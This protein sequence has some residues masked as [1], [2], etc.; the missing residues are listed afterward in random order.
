M[1]RVNRSSNLARKSIITGGKFYA[2]R[3]NELA[4]SPTYTAL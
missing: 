3:Y 2:S 4:F 1:Q